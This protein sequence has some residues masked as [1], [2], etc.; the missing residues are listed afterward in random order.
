MEDS[1]PPEGQTKG[2]F[3]PEEQTEGASSPEENFG[4]T[5]SPILFQND[6]H[7]TSSGDEETSEAPKKFKSMVDIMERAPRVE[8]D[9]AAQAI[10]AYILTKALG[11]SR[12]EDLRKQ[13]GV[14]SRYD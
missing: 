5:F 1:H 4:G 12:F 6:N 7:D 14:K 13:L 3:S 2:E 11:G 10:E 8:L 9:E